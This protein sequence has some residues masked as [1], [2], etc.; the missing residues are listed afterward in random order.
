RKRSPAG[1]ATTGAPGTNAG[2]TRAQE[3]R[4]RRAGGAARRR[5]GWPPPAARPSRAAPRRT[6]SRRAGLR[7]SSPGSGPPP[8]RGA[9]RK[10]FSLLA[11]VAIS[12]INCAFYY[13]PLTLQNKRIANLLLRTNFLLRASSQSCA[14]TSPDTFWI[15]QRERT[16]GRSR[17]VSRH[18]AVLRLTVQSLSPIADCTSGRDRF[19]FRE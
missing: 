13:S 12:Q 8:G 5:P 9:G 2:R 1:D 11:S 4:G 16:R 10:T 17:A 3:P 18:R 19:S 15:R 6:A 7:D 14:R